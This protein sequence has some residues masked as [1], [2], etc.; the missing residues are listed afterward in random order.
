MTD[1]WKVCESCWK[2][3]KVSMQRAYCIFCEE[4]DLYNLTKKQAGQIRKAFGDIKKGCLVEEI[5]KDRRFINEYN[6]E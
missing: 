6:K 1:V 4:R 3:Q 2:I 5:L